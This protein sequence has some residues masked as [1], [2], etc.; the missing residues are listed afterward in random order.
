MTIIVAKLVYPLFGWDAPMDKVLGITIIF[1]VLS[2]ARGY[3]MRRIFDYF[4]GGN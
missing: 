4:T 3:I 2:I 1:T